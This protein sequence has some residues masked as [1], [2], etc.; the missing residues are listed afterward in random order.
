LDLEAR[1]AGRTPPPSARRFEFTSQSFEVQ[2]RI[3]HLLG[4]P[5][6]VLKTLSHSGPTRTLGTGE[7][8]SDM[9][10]T[11]VRHVAQDVFDG[12]SM[13]ALAGALD[14][15]I[16]PLGFSL[17]HRV[18]AA[19]ES[20]EGV[21][22]T[23]IVGHRRGRRSRQLYTYY[24]LVFIEPA[25]PDKDADEHARKIRE[26]IN[27]ALSTA[28]LP[29]IW[30]HGLLGPEATVT[31]DR[32]L[33]RLGA[34]VVHHLE[35]SRP[36]RTG[37]LLRPPSQRSA[38][39]LRV[40]VMVSNPYGGSEPIAGAWSEALGAGHVRIDDLIRRVRELQTRGRGTSR[41]RGA[42]IT[43][44]AMRDGG[45]VVEQGLR[46]LETG[47]A[48]GAWN[49]SMETQLLAEYEPLRHALTNLEGVVVLVQ[50]GPA[51]Q[52]LAA[53]R[54][55]AAERDDDGEPVLDT[56]IQGERPTSDDLEVLH[57]HSDI[58]DKWLKRLVESES[59]LSGLQ[60][61]RDEMPGR[62]TLTAHLG[63][64]PPTYT[65]YTIRDERWQARTGQPADGEIA[66][67]PDSVDPFVDTWMDLAGDCLVELATKIGYTAND[68]EGL[69]ERLKF[70]PVR[71]RVAIA[72]ARSSNGAA[73]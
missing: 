59:L 42:F 7:E 14:A 20:V 41:E 10:E 66:V 17:R 15:N 48:P 67:F 30:E 45:F 18:A 65:W 28:G 64:L 60:A 53:W 36:P 32:P 47:R 16:E 61:Q 62:L 11:A 56:A 19:A 13:Q 55:A 4:E 44:E 57:Q 73:P 70:E 69:A 12:L 21:T 49:L 22:A 25:A 35:G 27:L 37:L 58:A 33:H 71:D 9:L 23:T 38:R 39:D 26:Q 68:L 2:R 63:E 50:L 54:A 8:P 40:A 24:V 31:S 34:L 5:I 29:A 72:A 1:K 52:R 6:D 3:A 51:W 46:L 43:D